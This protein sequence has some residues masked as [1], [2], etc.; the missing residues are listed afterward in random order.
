MHLS[1]LH[2]DLGTHN[3]AGAQLFFKLFNSSQSIVLTAAL[4]E[5]VVFRGKDHLILYSY[6]YLQRKAKPNKNKIH[7][8]S[9]QTQ[10]L[11]VG[12]FFPLLK[13]VSNIKRLSFCRETCVSA[14]AWCYSGGS[15]ERKR[16][17][18][19]LELQLQLWVVFEATV[20]SPQRLLSLQ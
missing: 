17:S 4:K 20:P 16:W 12:K 2:T 13:S 7:S 15:Q 6:V 9:A 10:L 11:L 5:I 3:G 19:H 1:D 18:D 14:R 8:H